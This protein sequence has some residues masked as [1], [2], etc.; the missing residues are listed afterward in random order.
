MAERSV[1]VCVCT[2]R[3]E[4]IAA[5]L[6]SLAHQELG[7][8]RM[9]VIVA[10]N[11]EHDG[12]R[13]RIEA[14]AAREG[15]ALTYLHAPARNISLAR[16]AALEA[17]RAPWIAVLD[18]DETAARGWLAA[19]L[20]AAERTGAE[21]V[22]GPVRASYHDD[23]PEWMRRG[24]FHSAEPPTRGGQIQTGYTSNVLFRRDV[25]PLEGQRFRLDLGRSGGEDTEFFH[26][27]W[28]AGARIAYAPDAVV[29][30]R[31]EPGRATL[32]WLARRR[33]RSGQSHGMLIA[34]SIKGPGGR[35]REVALA[36]AKVGA[37]AAAG[38]ASLP[39][40][41]RRAFWL[42]RGA[43]HAGVLSRLAGMRKLTIY[44]GEDAVASR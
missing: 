4:S 31:V 5:T 8:V 2:F 24:D 28:R 9:R 13:E 1:D 11:D 33:F 12:A 32:R 22:L 29:C 16:N 44:G 7:G 21:V 36:L 39:S 38:L 19:L 20:D 23:V 25:G 30:E 43:L 27:A 37:C 34:A 6:R 15:V 18:D 26:R 35:A 14:A 42:L 41:E 3:R 17:A 40:A 10:D